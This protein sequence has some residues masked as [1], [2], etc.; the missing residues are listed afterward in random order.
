MRM[1]A[2]SNDL[3]FVTLTIVSWV[4]LFTRPV[5]KEMI[6][7]NLEFCRKNKGLR[8]FYYVIMSNHIHMVVTSD[9]K[10]LS[11]ILRDFKTYTSKQL[12]AMIKDNSSESRRKWMKDIFTTAGAK[13]PANKYIQVW[14]NGNYPVLLYSDYMTEQ[15]IHYIHENP[16]RAGI[17]TEPEDYLYSSASPHSPLV[18]DEF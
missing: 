7:E 8:I 17:V 11:D 12:F 18:C 9:K 5:Y 16:V 2:R 1:S 4:D 3:F 6:V 14:Q 13:N 15:K 10:P